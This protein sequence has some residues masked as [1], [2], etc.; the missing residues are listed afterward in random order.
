MSRLVRALIHAAEDNYSDDESQPLGG[1]RDAHR[2]RSQS[3]EPR[4]LVSAE[5]VPPTPLRFSPNLI[6]DTSSSH[7]TALLRDCAKSAT[8]PIIHPDL[9]EKPMR[10][11]LQVD[12][13]ASVL[14]GYA[15]MLL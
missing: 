5:H 4:I 10:G 1:G 12:Y 7:F 3:I 11:A 6:A 15:G 13:P 14:V 8:R 9:Y 2:W